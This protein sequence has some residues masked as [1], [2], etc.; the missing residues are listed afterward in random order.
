MKSAQA[1]RTAVGLA[2][3][4]VASPAGAQQSAVTDRFRLNVGGF[5]QSF[6]TTVRLNTSDGIPGTEI[7][8]QD[9]L[10]MPGRQTNLRLD[11]YWRF[12]PRGS[13]QFAYR[14]WNLT[15]SRTIDRDIQFGDQTYHAGAQ[16]D[17][18][19]KVSVADLYYAYSLARAP[20]GEFGVGLGVSAY[21]NKVALSAT[22]LLAGS[23]GSTSAG[24]DQE[25]RS[26]VAPI[27]AI[28]VFL[29]VGLTETLY[30]YAR[31]KGV[32]GTIQGYHG[33]MLDGIAGL[34]LFVSRNVGIGA[35]Y[36]YVKI[37]YTREE[38]RGLAMNYK[39]SGPLAYLTIGF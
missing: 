15:S 23:G 34:D 25:E 10:G 32:T 35:G 33:A 28:L 1:F 21:F 29:R 24:I 31:A 6:D 38:P 3:L 17:S 37:E 12:G 8:L 19:L 4:C 36:E 39:F 5:L 7:N 30:A 18:R 22:G 13:L 26:L 16:V 20:Y 2:I 9:V 11:G 27:P 14:G